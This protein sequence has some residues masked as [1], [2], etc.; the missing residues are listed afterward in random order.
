MK[1]EEPST[2]V[3][4]E[5]YWN[6]R[7][8]G[9]IWFYDWA[10]F[11]PSWENCI[12]CKCA[13]FIEILRFNLCQFPFR[14]QAVCIFTITEMKIT[15]TFSKSSFSSVIIMQYIMYAINTNALAVG[16]SLVFSHVLCAAHIYCS[17]THLT[18]VR[19]LI[20]NWYEIN[21]ICSFRG[22]GHSLVPT[23]LQDLRRWRRIR[24]QHQQQY[25]KKA[26]CNKKNRIK[27]DL[28]WSC[29]LYLPL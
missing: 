23:P 16:I 11:Y 25:Y 19:W 7:E 6:R 10:V 4:R 9:I 27:Y 24:I 20:I 8:F 14:N 15:C 28:I 26:T 22:R 29:R 2:D 1:S 5:G 18:G 12:S 13:Y 21:L 3:Y 17:S